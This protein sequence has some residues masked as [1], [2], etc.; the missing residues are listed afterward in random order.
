MKI[1]KFC[2]RK[3]SYKPTTATL[4]VGVMVL[5][6]L[7]S[8][9]NLVSGA[10]P[11]SDILHYWNF[12]DGIN[13]SIG[14]L[15]LTEG[16]TTNIA[17]KSSNARYFDG[18]G[19]YL[20]M[21]HIANIAVGTINTWVLKNVSQTRDYVIINVGTTS[22]SLGLMT[23]R[24]DNGDKPKI[25]LYA[26]G[27]WQE[28]SSTDT[29]Q[30]LSWQMVTM[31]WNTT[32]SWAYIN[33]VVKVSN[34]AANDGVFSASCTHRIGG[35]G[36]D[37]DWSFNGTL[38]EIGIWDR[39][40]TDT[41]ITDLYN[42]G[43][44]E[45]YRIEA[46]NL[47]VGLLSPIDSSAESSDIIF[48]A[49]ITPTSVNITNATLHIWFT[50]ST[51]LT[52]NTTLIGGN[53]TVNTSRSIS[54][55]T[56]GDYL[57]NYKSC[58][59][60][61]STGV[62]IDCS[63]ATA[64]YSLTWRP[65][66]V[67]SVNYST[68]AL[69][70][71]LQRFSI[72][73]S[74]TSGYDLQNAKLV[75]N[76]TEYSSV[77]K[78]ATGGGNYTLSKSIT[79]PG[80]VSGFGTE[81]RTFFWN[82]S[83]VNE[84]SGLASYHTSDSYNQTVN[85]LFF[86]LCSATLNIS[87]INFTLVDEQN[88]SEINGASNATTFQGTFSIG[89]RPGYLSKTYSINNLSTALTRFDFCT[90]NYTSPIYTDL[91]LFYTAVDYTE[92][93]YYL[94]NASLDN[95]TNEI[96]LYLLP[97]TE[98]LEFFLKVEQ[99]LNSVASA[100][101]NIEKYFVGEGAYKTVEIDETDTDG[102]FTSYLDL[103]KQY[104]FTITKD[105]EVLGIIYKRATC[106]AAPCEILLSISSEYDN[107]FTLF[108]T[109]FASNVLY[110]LS[111]DGGTKMVVFDFID[112]TG[113]ATYFRMVI[114]QSYANQSAVSIYDNSLYTSSGSMSFNMTDY[115]GD[116]RVE[117]YVSRS[118]ES[119]IDFILITLSSVAGELGIM[120]L[121]ISFLFVMVIIFGLSFK[122]SVLVMAVPLALTIV[123]LMGIM[124]LSTA[125]IIFVYVL[126]IIATMVISK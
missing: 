72:N 88:G 80:G 44:G 23:G 27:S 73:V 76:G 65:F 15:N 93:N 99:N 67:V 35:T 69:E 94:N 100:T 81:N 121:F 113:L 66:T 39:Q 75:Y 20:N 119:F 97:E 96:N 53:I 48:N 89:A 91:N 38:D 63:W 107:P 123:K 34:V 82:V 4:L 5:V 77:T 30:N 83:V 9:L 52:T 114:Y 42:G 18:Y 90:A 37:S 117:T 50:N 6:A 14:T 92:K 7:F 8:S 106:D 16:G 98:A 31:T 62:F 45:F 101:V 109:T 115:S 1:D 33:S 86:G 56:S 26:G 47:T 118:P 108:D 95:I 10:F 24:S 55:W 21:R 102:E 112:T 70:T 116:F 74:T 111:Y 126:A 60:N 11:T 68:S 58:Y 46:E 2:R 43:A 61:S 104:R 79:I 122:P 3:T 28:T 32:G 110:N 87:L 59:E 64:N 41:E 51:L 36:S 22:G 78:T 17:G 71:S 12:D 29:F 57:W 19:D 25:E 105:G 124:T 120:G 125:S 54:N 103:D 40:L 85:E 13:D 49:T 84:A